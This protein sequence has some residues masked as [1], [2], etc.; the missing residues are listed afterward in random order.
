MN[1]V[2]VIRRYNE[3][4]FFRLVMTFVTIAAAMLLMISSSNA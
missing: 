2:K 1:T 3:R 4:L